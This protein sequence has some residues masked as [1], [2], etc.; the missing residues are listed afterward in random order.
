MSKKIK[1]NKQLLVEGNDDSHF[2][3]AFCVKIKITENFE[4]VDCKGIDGLRKEIPEHLKQPN[5]NT[6]GIIVDADTDLSHIW[7]SLKDLLAMQSFI[8]PENI[9]QNGLILE[10]NDDQKVGIWIMPN[11]DLM[12]TLED[13]VKLLIPKDDNLKQVVEDTLVSIE[14]Q[15]FNKYAPK[16]RQKAFINTWLAWQ[17]E[18]GLPMGRAITQKILSTSNQ[19]AQNF[20]DWLTELFN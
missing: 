1:F 17:E 15:K 19:N 20:S 7:L 18:S 10:N 9:P 2:V 16:D 13:F 12:G 11:N 4:I 5:I 3:S 8:F 6:I 14:T